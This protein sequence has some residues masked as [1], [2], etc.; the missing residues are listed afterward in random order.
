MT[1]LISSMQDSSP[2]WWVWLCC[3]LR[4]CSLRERVSWRTISA[5]SIRC[6]E[7]HHRLGQTAFVLLLI[8]PVAHALRFIP[9]RFDRALLFL[10]PSHEKL[11][12][13]LGAYAFWGLVP[14]MILTLFV[15]IPYDEWKLSHKFLGLVLVFGTIHI[16]TI[17]STRGR[18][19]AVLQNPLL[20]YYMLGL[21]ALGVIS[22]CYKLIVLPL[23]SRRCMYKVKAVKRFSDEVLQ[24]ELSPRRRR[25]TFTPGQFVFVTFY[26]E[27]LSRE[28]HPFTIC[29]VPE[30]K[31]VELTV[32]A[33]GDFT[34]ALHR[35]LRSGAGA[36]V[37]GPMA[38]SI[39]GWGRLSRSGSPRASVSRPF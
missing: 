12:V 36:K 15:K 22:F 18:P 16:L 37:E 39:I 14:L 38:A 30:Q 29:T 23:L 28:A 20:R 27:G 25:V 24:I 9:E 10:L 13:N 2:G 33:L 8:H 11:A 6:I 21:A 35:Q 19:V 32:K 7:I 31:D 34:N 3:R 26:Q 4:S 17:E 5:D 1:M